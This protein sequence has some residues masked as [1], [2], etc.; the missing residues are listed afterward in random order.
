MSFKENKDSGLQY[1]NIALS[2]GL[3]LIITVYFLYKGG[4]WLDKRFGTEPFFMISGVFL[5]LATIFWQL[6]EEFGG[7]QTS[8]QNLQQEREQKEEENMQKDGEEL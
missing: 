8:R 1:L 5:A 3:T 6:I 7:W 2:F 4:T